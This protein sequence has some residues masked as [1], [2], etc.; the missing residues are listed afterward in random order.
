M[1]LFYPQEDWDIELLKENN[2]IVKTTFF[3]SLFILILVGVP[4]Y[5]YIQGE[6]DKY[7]ATQKLELKNTI[8][9]LEKKI[10]SIQQEQI[11]EL[12]MPLTYDYYIF[13]K[14]KFMIFATNKDEDISFEKFEYFKNKKFFIITHLQTNHLNGEYLVVSKEFNDKEI[15]L[16][17]AII[18]LV[19]VLFVFISLYFV[20]KSTIEPLQKANIYLDRF[21]N[22]AMH[23]LRTPLGIISI[24]LEI[25]EEKLG[26]TKEI[27]RALHGIKGLN[28][29]YE[30]IE[31][32][33]KRKSVEYRKE[34]VNFSHFLHKRVE[35]F[36]DLASI[37]D[38]EFI[39]Y[40][41]ENIY[42]DFNKTELQRIVDNN[43][44][45]AIK[46][47]KKSSK[48][49]VTLSQKEDKITF[50]VEDFGIGIKDK[51]AIF[52]RYIKEDDIKGGF[53]IGL[54]I[55]KAI[56]DKNSVVI[57]IDSTLA[58]GSIFTYIFK[59]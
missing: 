31:Y 48:I 32:L 50:S 13:D 5:F 22:D 21:F 55:V 6:Y 36:E 7:K 14:D 10:L 11:L 40:I 15:V 57:D 49:V 12:P 58:K 35:F 42:I 28:S 2:Y 20:F 53:G 24:N 25:L 34:K 37:K 54:S 18:V 43:L 3:Y 16:K 44:S 4:S 19:L 46:Y 17:I 29:I 39:L 52:K 1:S 9:N 51:K 27:Q 23:E 30:D 56:C 8:L 45:N 26:K 47:S 33:I 41:Q 59:A 38:I